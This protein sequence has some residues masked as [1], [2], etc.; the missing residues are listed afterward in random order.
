MQNPRIRI[1]GK[2]NENGRIRYWIGVSTQLKD[3]KGQPLEDQYL[4]ASITCDLSKDAEQCFLTNAQPTN[5]PA[6][7]QLYC[8]MTDGWLKAVKAKP[9]PFVAIFV[10]RIQKAETKKQQSPAW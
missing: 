8:E 2:K 6:V 9:Y 3:E 4:N 10:N 5:N 1:N 7:R